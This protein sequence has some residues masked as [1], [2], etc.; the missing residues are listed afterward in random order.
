MKFLASLIIALSIVAAA[1]AQNADVHFTDGSVVRMSIAQPTVEV[2]TKYGKLIVPV[3]DIRKIEVG[4]HIPADQAK[5]IEHAIKRLSSS[6]W[7]EREAAGKDLV[8]TGHL[9]LPALRR[10][11]FSSDQ[12]VAIR[13]DALVKQIVEK[14][15]AELASLRDEDVLHTT[16]GPITGRL[17]AP[18]IAAKS[19]YFGNVTL[20]LADVRG[21][22]MRHV[23]VMTFA[24]DAGDE[25]KQMDFYVD[26]RS[27]LTIDASG[28]VD[29]FPQAA[30]QY[31]IGPKGYHTTGKGSLFPAGSLIGKIGESG[32]IFVIGEQYAGEM[33]EEGRL[34]LMIVPSPWNNVSVGQYKV[35]IEAK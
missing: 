21:M 7:K 30:G 15:P 25:W 1:K 4:L 19:T 29:I 11:A 3:E 35:R 20:S 10:A 28:Q 12:E 31:I 14:V 27:R 13:A 8:Q 9:A 6:V 5:Q 32:R 17:L 16:E 34:Y 18:T 33:K 24:V 2:Q 23:G 22:H 26:G